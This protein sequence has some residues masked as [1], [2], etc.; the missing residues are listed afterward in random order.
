MCCGKTPCA[1][2]NAEATAAAVSSETASASASETAAEPLSVEEEIALSG[3]LGQEV[4]RLTKKRMT[5]TATLTGKN[6]L[7]MESTSNF[8]SILANSCVFS[9]KW[10][11]EI[12][13]E[14]AGIQ[15]LGWAI[16]DCR[17]RGDQ[18]EGERECL[19]AAGFG[20]Q[21]LDKA[22]LTKQEGKKKERKNRTKPV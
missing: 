2:R 8:C 20:F 9:G 4:V 19:R 3:R 11:Y 10:M 18:G 21:S 15:Q 16:P 22:L 17:F 7:K 12:T 6:G 1:G 5:G 13:L 14:T